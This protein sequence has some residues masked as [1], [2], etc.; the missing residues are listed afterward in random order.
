MRQVARLPLRV[1]SVS[2]GVRTASEGRGVVVSNRFAPPRTWPALLICLLAPVAQAQSE[3]GGSLEVHGLVSQGFIKSTQ[4]NYL[5]ESRRGSFEFFEAGLNFTRP[6]GESLRVGGQLFA[7]DLGP[8]GDYSAKVDWFFLDWRAHNWLGVRAGRVKLPYGLYNHQ[9]DYDPGRLW[10]LMPQSVYPLAQRDVLVG[11][12]GVEL[13]G[14]VPLGGVGALSWSALAGTIFLDPALL[15]PLLVER[16]DVSWFAFGRLFW[17]PPMQGLKVGVSTISTRFELDTTVQAQPLTAATRL[18]FVVA[19]AEL[20]RGD[21]L[22]AAEYARQF[23]TQSSNQ[24]AIVPS[25]SLVTEGYHVDGAYYLSSRLAVGA[26]YAGLFGDVH[27]RSGRDAYQHDV[28]ATV[29][30][31]LTLNWLLKLEAHY[32]EGTATLDPLLNGGRPPSELVP[33]WGLFL[34]KTTAYF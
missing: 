28:A 18:L 14:E 26:Y 5:A 10:I 24:P 11:V 32:I 1:R 15:S 17:E 3:D 27:R 23:T 20:Q 13:Y 31:D 33:S 9:T 34:A 29:R 21:L 4:N 6:L 7:R 25:R 22:L 19:S 2:F 30:V 16:A 8:L 12:T